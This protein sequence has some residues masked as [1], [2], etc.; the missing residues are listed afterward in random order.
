M[1]SPVGRG[2]S[3][4]TLRR[5]RLLTT[6]ASHD[7][8]RALTGHL[9]QV[10]ISDHGQYSRCIAVI[11]QSGVRSIPQPFLDR[12]S[13]LLKSAYSMALFRLLRLAAPAQQQVHFP[14]SYYALSL[15]PCHNPDFL[16]P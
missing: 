8:T 5:A 13:T 1:T 16:W 11:D 7:A 3:K 12:I 9:L 10:S 14:T 6:L 15:P 2:Q 4:S